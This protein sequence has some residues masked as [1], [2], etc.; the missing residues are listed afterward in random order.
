MENNFI[1]PKQCRE[2]NPYCDAWS[3]FILPRMVSLIFLYRSTEFAYILYPTL[4]LPY[5]FEKKSKNVRY[6]ES[7]LFKDSF[8]ENILKNGDL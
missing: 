6:T 7:Q 3:N 5:D 8:E 2:A 4:K 1:G